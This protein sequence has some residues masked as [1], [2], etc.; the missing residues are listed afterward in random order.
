[1]VGERQEAGFLRGKGMSFPK[2]IQC[3][4]AV[5]HGDDRVV[6]RFIMRGEQA[7]SPWTFGLNR[8]DFDDEGP[9]DDAL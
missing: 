3:R 6:V 9:I 4:L 7:P 2:K 1:M 8:C 5:Y